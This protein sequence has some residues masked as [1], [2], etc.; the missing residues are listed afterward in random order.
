MS[1]GDRLDDPMVYDVMRELATQLGGRYV[2][3]MDEA[4]TAA[5]EKHWQSEQ[6]RVMREARAVDPDNRQAIEAHTARLR[7]ELAAMPRYAPVLA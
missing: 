2:E 4:M 5:D 3:W 1:D 6:S 7:A